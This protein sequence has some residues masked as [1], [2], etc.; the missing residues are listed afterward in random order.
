[1][2]WTL[3]VLLGLGAYAFKAAG[4]V[5]IGDRR[6]P[7]VL[8]R[9]IGL[10]P[11]ALIGAILVKDTLT[12]GRH[13]QLDARAAGIATAFIL[14]WRRAPFLA[15]VLAACAVTAILRAL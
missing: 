7:P 3:V 12:A 2:T 4:L 6:L 9:C 8:E 15:I 13:I 5:I 10:I 14:A 1:M 11:A